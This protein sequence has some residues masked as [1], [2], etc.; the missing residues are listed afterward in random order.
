MSKKKLTN[1]IMILILFPIGSPILNSMHLALLFFLGLG[2]LLAQR[3][4]PLCGAN[5]NPNSCTP[6]DTSRIGTL[7]FEDYRVT[8]PNALLLDL[9]ARRTVINQLPP[10]V[11]SQLCIANPDTNN[12][13]NAPTVRAASV[14]V[15]VNERQTLTTSG[16]LVEE[17]Y[18]QVTANSFLLGDGLFVPQ[19]VFRLSRARGSNQILLTISPEYLSATSAIPNLESTFILAVD[20]TTTKVTFVT[21]Q[22]ANA[23]IL[24]LYWGI[25]ANLPS[26]VNTTATYKVVVPPPFGKSLF[27]PDEVRA[28]ATG[29]QSAILNYGSPVFTPVPQVSCPAD[30]GAAC[31]ALNDLR[32]VTDSLSLYSSDYLTFRSR[33]AA[34]MLST[35]LLNWAKANSLRTTTIEAGGQPVDTYSLMTYLKPVALFW[36]LL[37]QDASILPA[38]KTTIT[39]WLTPLY[40][41]SAQ[42][43]KY[44]NNWGTMSASIRMMDA[45]SRRDHTAFAETVERYFVAINQLRADGSI[46][47]EA[48]HGPCSLTYTNLAINN[49]VQLAETAATQGYDLY[50]LAANG[51]SIHTAI[52]F[53]LDASDAPTVLGRYYDPT[54]AC[55]LVQSAPADQSVFT[56][57]PETSSASAWMEIYLARFP[58]TTLSDRLRRK[59]GLNGLA[60]RPLYS[61]MAGANTSCLFFPREELVPLALPFLDILSGN[62]QTAPINT[63][64]PLPLTARLRSQDGTPTPNVPI[65]FAISGLPASLNASTIATST[66]GLA[67]ALLTTGNRSGKL[68][69]TAAI[70]QLPPVSFTITVTGDDPKIST[71]GLAGAGSSVPPVRTA[72]PGTILSIYGA[73]FVAAGAGRRVNASEIVNAKLPTRL[74]GI[75]V[76]FDTTPASILDVYPNQLNV[77]VP[78]VKGTSAL[79]RVIKN[80]GAANELRSEPEPVV[81]A[82]ASPEFF[83]SALSADGV[84]PVAALNATTNALVGP[85]TLPPAGTFRPINRGGIVTVYMNGLGVTTPANPPGTVPTAAAALPDTPVIRIG[86]LIVPPDDVLYAGLA[87]GLVI[88]QVNFRVPATTPIG[89]NLLSISVRGISTPPGG[90]LAVAP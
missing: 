13:A 20:Q 79:V 30:P 28:L 16:T 62:N 45:I 53:L 8:N 50:S 83:F 71:G 78:D 81:L 14:I 75:C 11:T 38:D 31:T 5:G 70:P 44:S 25:A 61:Y 9:D 82:A 80:C 27:T 86:D 26:L 21:P 63:A 68:T 57:T 66:A 55:N 42:A 6:L 49:L 65:T 69:V 40:S 51:Q 67:P 47:E 72:S 12:V 17:V 24:R 58:K 89:N 59:I 74:L 56:L 60:S 64:L 35:N 32:A 19:M 22:P 4:A 43:M 87:P 73:D 77:V 33:P 76:N 41:T 1:R 48:K 2:S 36:P 15:D 54:A 10:N 46:P 84:N 37:S 88:Y 85:A 18:A 29:F 34:K 7:R 90:Y 39:N 3:T 23:Q 52:Q